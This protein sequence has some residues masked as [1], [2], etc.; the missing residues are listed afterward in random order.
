MF[1]A[2]VI[3]FDEWQQVTETL[4]ARIDAARCAPLELPDVDD[5][6]TAWH[7]KLRD[8]IIAKRLVITALVTKLTVAPARKGVNRFDETRIDLALID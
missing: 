3:D 4:A 2:G 6:E 7:K 8:D 5:I 1:R